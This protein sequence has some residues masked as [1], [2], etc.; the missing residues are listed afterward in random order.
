MSEWLLRDLRYGSR[1]LWRSPGFA[2]AAG[3]TSLRSE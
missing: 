1:Q 3:L 2:L